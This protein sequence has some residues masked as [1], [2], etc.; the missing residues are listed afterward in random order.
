MPLASALLF[1]AL[2]ASSS[3]PTLRAADK[4]FEEGQYQRVLPLV[5]QVLKEDLSPKDRR[6]AYELQALTYAAFDDTPSAI[7][8]FQRVLGVTPW[9]EP[10]ASASPKVKGLFAEAKRRGPRLT[11]G[12]VPETR[13][14]DVPLVQSSGSTTKVPEE[15]ATPL[16]RRW[17]FWTA[18]AVVAAGTAGAVWYANSAQV[19]RGS[20]GTA[21]IP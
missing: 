8:A 15:K 16:Y 12:V 11:P 21:E 19:P 9:Y 10:E 2:L 17:W 3:Q 4:S 5:D 20:L 6:R 18:I 7:E 1:A 14:A 13:P